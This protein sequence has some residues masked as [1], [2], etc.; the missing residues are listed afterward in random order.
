MELARSTAMARFRRDT[1]TAEI[2]AS[3]L[4]PTQRKRG[5]AG[6]GRIKSPG[7]ASLKNGL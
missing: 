3:P 5:S 2:S 6:N 1:P 4:I 7:W